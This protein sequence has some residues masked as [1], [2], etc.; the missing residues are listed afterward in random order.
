MAA[1]AVVV[2]HRG[3]NERSRKAERSRADAVGTQEFP[4]PGGRSF[5]NQQPDSKDDNGDDGTLDDV[6]TELVGESIG[7]RLLVGFLVGGPKMSMRAAYP[8][9]LKCAATSGSHTGNLATFRTQ[10]QLD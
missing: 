2:R 3:A 4:P 6:M 1:V 7:G 9:N 8:A 10:K 5:T